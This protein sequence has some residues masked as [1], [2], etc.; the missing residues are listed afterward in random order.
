MPRQTPSVGQR[1]DISQY[2]GDFRLR[3]MGH[4]LGVV[5]AHI[6]RFG[7]II[8]PGTSLVRAM[9]LLDK[10]GGTVWFAEGTYFIKEPFETSRD[11][12]VW[13]AI[14]PRT[15][16]QRVPAETKTVAQGG[17]PMLTFNGARSQLIGFEIEDNPDSSYSSVK[18][19]GDRSIVQDCHFVDGYNGVE[20]AGSLCRVSHNHFKGASNRGVFLTGT[21]SRNMVEANTFESSGIADYDIY[22]DDNVTDGGAV[23]NNHEIDATGLAISVK[24]GNNVV[25]DN[26]AFDKF[27]NILDIGSVQTR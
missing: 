25:V 9:M 2:P 5:Q 1:S 20:I 7:N 4:D 17:G 16:I 24:G 19:A 22:F 8:T 3:N 15:K 13:R 11:N 26:T 21:K 18:M 27:Y 23:S 12:V 10:D 6:Q 14:G